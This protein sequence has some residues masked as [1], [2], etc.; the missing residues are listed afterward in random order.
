MLQSNYFYFNNKKSV[1]NFLLNI[2]L[3]WLFPVKHTYEWDRPSYS[4]STRRKINVKSGG[5]FT[6][7]D[8]PLLV[9][10]LL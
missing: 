4:S 3:A 6:R 5:H 1:S 8:K 10:L 7:P 2:I 9:H